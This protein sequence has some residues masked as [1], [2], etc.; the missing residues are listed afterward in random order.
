[1]GRAAGWRGLRR[2]L[3]S[4]ASEAEL[5][6]EERLRV[7]AA[8]EVG[9]RLIAEQPPHRPLAD[10]AA[11]A[12]RY[13]AL[14][15]EEVEH[16]IAVGLDSGRRPIVEH[17]IGGAVDGVHAQPRDL[18]RPMIAAGA[19]AMIVIHNHPSGCREP[20][21]SDVAFTTRLLHAGELCGVP[22]LDHVIVAGAGWTSLAQ[23]G[24]LGGDCG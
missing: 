16:L 17:R 13:R 11:V 9:R 12:L 14:G 8:L 24:V 20:S 3:Q 5:A 2:L 4:G 21:T 19:V 6:P 18:L 15:L 1:M 22:L 23:R 10:P 7:A